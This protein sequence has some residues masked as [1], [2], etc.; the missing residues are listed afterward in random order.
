MSHDNPKASLKMAFARVCQPLPLDFNSDNTSGS[1]RI[2]VEI[3][4]FFKAGRPRWTGASSTLVRHFLL[5]RSGASSAS[6]QSWCVELLFPSICFPHTDNATGRAARCPNQNHH[7]VSQHSDRNETIFPIVLPVIINCNKWPSKYFRGFHHIKRTM[8]KCQTAF[9]RIAF[10]FH[11][12]IVTTTNNGLQQA[13]PAISNVIVILALGFQPTLASAKDLGVHGPLFDVA[14]PSILD[15]IKTRLNQMEQSGELDVM[16]KEMQDTTKT[17]VNRPRPVKGLGKAIENVAWDVDLSIT[18]ERDLA[19][20][21]G[22]IFAHVGTVV[23]P[24]GFSRFNK[25]IVLLDGDDP[26][27]VQFA[28]SEGDEL[29]TLLVLVN[30]DPLGLMRAHGRRFYFDQDAVLVDRFGIRN[31]PAVVSRADP[32]MRVEEIAVGEVEE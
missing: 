21:N 1:S 5:A 32:L 13:K 27:Q 15:A 31:V 23:N 25:R 18:L 4:G 10:N 12:I 30:G 26:A 22:R 2:V 9:R 11:T 14:E 20:Q 28:L 3:L 19:D 29:N 17:Y 16:K 6:T 24:M 7:S 8:L